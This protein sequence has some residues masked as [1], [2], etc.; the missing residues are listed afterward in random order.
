M[1]SIFANAPIVPTVAA[2]QVGKSTSTH[3]ANIAATETC[4]HEYQAGRHY[5]RAP[6]IADLFVCDADAEQI[7]ARAKTKGIEISIWPPRRRSHVG[8]GSI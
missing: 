7:V 4:D 2:V 5:W 8:T 6:I 1:G 3:R